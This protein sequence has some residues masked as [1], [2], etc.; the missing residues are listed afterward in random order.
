MSAIRSAL[1]DQVH[2]PRQEHELEPDERIEHPNGKPALHHRNGTQPDHDHAFQ[3]EDQP[4]GGALEDPDVL[5]LHASISLVHDEILV[6]RSSLRF[7]QV[8]LDCH[9][10]A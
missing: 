10:P 2:D 3:A 4:V 8:Q 1:L 5:H 7:T 9:H 6:G